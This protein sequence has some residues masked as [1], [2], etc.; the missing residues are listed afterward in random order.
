MFK[1][2]FTIALRNLAHN[3]VY[4]FINIAG[5]TIGLTC[6]MLIL[7]YVKDEVSF[8]RFHD[9]SARIYRITLSSF[10]GGKRASFPV[11]VC[12]KAPGS[13]NM[14]PGLSHLCVCRMDG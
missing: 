1:N 9:K 10:N 5:L 14:S 3:K 4:S 2:Y 7:L 6:A 11:L 13:P 12:Y 8:D